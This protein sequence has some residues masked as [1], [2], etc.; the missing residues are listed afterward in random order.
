MCLLN[1]LPPC[2]SFRSPPVHVDCWLLL[3]FS[4]KFT[5]TASK[6]RSKSAEQLLK[7]MNS[8]EVFLS[9]H[10]QI[11]FHWNHI[12]FSAS[13]CQPKLWIPGKYFSLNSFIFVTNILLLTDGKIQITILILRRRPYLVFLT[14]QFYICIFVTTILLQLCTEP[15]VFWN[16]TMGLLLMAFSS[17]LSTSKHRDSPQCYQ[18]FK[19]RYWYFEARYRYFEA[20]YQYFMARYRYFEAWYQYFEPRYRYFEARNQYFGARYWYL[21]FLQCSESFHHVSKG[22]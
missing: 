13:A 3:A 21:P 8:R 10:F 20:G 19:A 4:L 11:C 2:E 15:T 7:L 14:H 22:R 18:Y 16:C 17:K 1:H 5:A 12:I 9:P 6:L